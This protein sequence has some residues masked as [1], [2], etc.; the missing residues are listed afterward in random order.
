MMNY[1]IVEGILFFGGL[2]MGDMRARVTTVAI[3]VPLLLVCCYFGGW[4]MALLCAFLAVLAA[5]ELNMLF[6]RRSFAAS[7]LLGAPAALLLTCTFGLIP[8]MIW[9]FAVA[10]LLTMLVY[11][12]WSRFRAETPASGLVRACATLYV[13]VGFGALLALRLGFGD[14]RWVLL[15]FFNVWLTDSAA[16]LV[17]SLFG[18]HKLAPGISPNKTW[19]GAIAG[20]ICGPLICSV[21][22]NMA[23]QMRFL[24]ALPLALLF[25]A[26]A[27]A[28][29]LLES[30]FKRWAGVKD[31]GHI[32]PGHGGVLDRFDSLFLSAPLVLF[33]LCFK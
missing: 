11:V 7:L 13:G 27:Q 9:P 28:G 30:A 31:S 24:S 18:R 10:V 14:W 20:L 16:H 25:S 23:L 32:F 19:E 17:G 1:F 21:Y 22:M 8:G 33:L 12:F 6:L 15:A 26:L 5:Y 4:L 3:G 2:D 29:D